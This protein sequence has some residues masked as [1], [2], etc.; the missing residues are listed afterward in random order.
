MADYYRYISR[1]GKNQMDLTT[2]FKYLIKNIEA[3]IYF[4]GFI[5]STCDL[6]D[7]LADNPDLTTTID[8]NGD[9]VVCPR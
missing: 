9:L 4:D 8:N 5:I 3:N 6:Y 2:I 1:K 7:L